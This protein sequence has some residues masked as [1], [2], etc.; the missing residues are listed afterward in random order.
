MSKAAKDHEG[1]FDEL[2]LEVHKRMPVD[3]GASNA[4]PRVLHRRMVLMMVVRDCVES[5]MPRQLE[6]Q[7]EPEREK[8][9]ELLAAR[10]FVADDYKSGVVDV[11]LEHCAL[12]IQRSLPCPC[13]QR[14]NACVNERIC[15]AAE[16]Q[17]VLDDECGLPVLEV[18]WH[19]GAIE[20]PSSACNGTDMNAPT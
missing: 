7:E 3:D 14:R 6:S 17:H 8:Y 12:D 15:L 10:L 9:V 1:T 18:A 19:L 20:A 5:L 13:S 16:A 4:D 11:E 2:R